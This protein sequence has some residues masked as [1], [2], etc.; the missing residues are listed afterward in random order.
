MSIIVRDASVAFRSGSKPFLEK[1]SFTLHE[2]EVTLLV[3]RS[4]SGKST[5]LD[6][7][8]GLRELQSGSIYVGNVSLWKRRKLEPTVNRTIGFVFQQPEKQLFAITVQREFHY[9]LRHLSLTRTQVDQRMNASLK[10]VRL[11]L[12][13]SS[14]SPFTLSAGQKRRVSLATT[15]ATEP[16]WLMLDEPSASLD[17]EGTSSLIKCIENWRAQSGCGMVIATHDLGTFVPLADRI[18][19]LEDGAIKADLRMDEVWRNPAILSQAGVKLPPALALAVELQAA[20][21]PIAATA[22]AEECAL[23]IDRVLRQS[24][25]SVGMESGKEEA[26]IGK[27]SQSPS[28]NEHKKTQTLITASDEDKLQTNYSTDKPSPFWKWLQMLDPRAKWLFLMLTSA[29]ILLQQHWLAI[30][31]ATLAVGCLLVLSCFPLGRI[32]PL[33]RAYFLF[34]LISFL[35]SGLSLG[36]DEYTGVNEWFSWNDALATAKPLLRLVPAML[37]GVLFASV[38]SPTQVRR[39][40][41]QSLSFSIKM[42][43]LVNMLTFTTSMMFRLIPLLGQEFER[44]SRIVR[45]RGKSDVKAGKIKLRDIHALLIPYLLSCFQLADQLSL[46]VEARGFRLLNGKP[47]IRV[48]KFR[49][50]D[51]FV[52]VAGLGLF[53]LMGLFR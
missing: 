40:M 42:R 45:S 43:P 52:M 33:L 53:L 24:V 46:A 6:M 1:V 5:L 15:F 31:T 34:T 12:N 18:L 10:M 37:L 27:P 50:V 25:D 2:G 44:F 9:S 19:V 32:K 41:D 26:E 39:A 51:V 16:N 36:H 3:G 14:S 11:P 48:L 47:A 29:G 22:L 30:G 17:Q 20:G 13:M 28:E 23:S 49:L 35:I 7:L 38:T 21:F 8:T 4:G